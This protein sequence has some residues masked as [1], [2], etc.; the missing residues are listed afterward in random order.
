MGIVPDTFMGIV[1]QIVGGS[2]ALENIWFLGSAL[3]GGQHCSAHNYDLWCDS[4]QLLPPPIWQADLQKP[5]PGT[6]K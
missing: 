4:N 5:Q 2:A 6:W 1:G 3:E